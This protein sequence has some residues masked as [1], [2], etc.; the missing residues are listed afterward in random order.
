MKK[1]INSFLRR[2]GYV[3][4]DEVS[5][6]L[7]NYLNDHIKI[8]TDDEKMKIDLR[9]N[10]YQFMF[11]DCVTAVHKLKKLEEYLKVN[12]VVDTDKNNNTFV[13]YRKIKK[14]K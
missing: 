14:T 6:M 1:L 8:L 13:G 10:E 5:V 4:E 12:Y 2:W 9:L 11:S 3:T 7:C